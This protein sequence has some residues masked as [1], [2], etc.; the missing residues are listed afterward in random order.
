MR[1]TIHEIGKTYQ[2][3]LRSDIGYS[4]HIILCCEHELI[5]HNPLGINVQHCARVQQHALVILDGLI[6]L[7]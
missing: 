7:P 3:P 2:Q 6:S 1:T 5:I 4:S